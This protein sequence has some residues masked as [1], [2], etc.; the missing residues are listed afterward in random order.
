MREED[1]EWISI[2]EA[3]EIHDEMV[4]LF[5]GAS[6]LRDR[7]KL[8]GAVMAVQQTWDQELLHRSLAEIAAGY[9]VY[10]A[11]DHPF[12]D[13]N[14][15]TALAVAMTFLHMNGY[16]KMLKRFVTLEDTMVDVVMKQ[17]TQEDL[18]QIFAT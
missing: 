1:I 17:I 2:D 11:T 4:R 13:G 7:G 18:A 9:A 12:V 6:G 3:I 16:L 5:G 15:R 14:K 8:E 10:I